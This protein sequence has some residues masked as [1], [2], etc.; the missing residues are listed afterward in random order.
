MARDA[1]QRM[2]S[3]SK[4]SQVLHA[5]TTVQLDAAL[6]RCRSVLSTVNAV[7]VLSGLTEDDY[8]AYAER[9]TSEVADGPTRD[10]LT[11]PHAASSATLLSGLEHIR[12]GDAVA[13]AATLPSWKDY[14]RRWHDH[15]VHRRDAS[16]RADMSAIVSSWI[17][18]LESARTRME[19]AA[20]T[21]D[22]SDYSPY[23]TD[24]E[25]EEE[26]ETASTSSTSSSQ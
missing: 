20:D 13:G 21:G 19:R 24:E 10:V 18:H 14:Q 9:R 6:R 23:S 25:E 16:I 2:A 7:K 1:Q 17:S 15:C 5:S 3:E 11:S 26:E 12:G 4:L 22:Y 8:S